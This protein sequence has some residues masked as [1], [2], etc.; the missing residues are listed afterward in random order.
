VQTDLASKH[1]WIL[2]QR[3]LP[4]TAPS[5][6]GGD[7]LIQTFTLNNGDTFLDFG[8]NL[9]DGTY[10]DIRIVGR[11]IT[12][13]D[14][15]GNSAANALK[16]QVYT[17]GILRTGAAT[18]RNFGQANKTNAHLLTTAFGVLA[19]TFGTVAGGSFE[20]DARIKNAPSTTLYKNVYQTNIAVQSATV[21]PATGN[22]P[23]VNISDIAHG[24]GGPN[25]T[26]NDSWIYVGDTLNLTGF[27][28]FLDY[29]VGA[30]TAFFTG[31][32][33]SVYGTVA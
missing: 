13:A 12:V 20:F 19:A 7:Q 18:Y 26:E 25:A 32:T 24:G 9:L 22:P 15:T 8:A 4:V 14:G 17:N 3:P 33:I 28:L 27:Y 6:P 1:G 16:M 21:S 2:E 11:G 31:G 30:N 29:P 5:A 23:S 10:T